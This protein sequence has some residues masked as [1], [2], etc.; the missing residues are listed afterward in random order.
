MAMSRPDLTLPV[1]GT[2]VTKR[3]RSA[4]CGVRSEDEFYRACS[5]SRPGTIRAC[6]RG[7][8]PTSPI[9][10][11]PEAFAAS[12]GTWLALAAVGGLVAL[13]VGILVHRRE[14]RLHPELQVGNGR[15][16]DAANDRLS[17]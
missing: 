8:L 14:M 6:S 7:V 1:I 10:V 17:A 4:Q 3:H 16:T 9:H 13:V 5:R 2:G 12:V 11:A 15:G